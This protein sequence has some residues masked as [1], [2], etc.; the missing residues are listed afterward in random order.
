MAIYRAPYLSS[1][2]RHLSLSPPSAETFS[3]RAPTLSVA[4]SRSSRHA[5]PPR[6]SPLCAA[7]SLGSA[8]SSSTPAA[9][10][11]A[12]KS[13]GAPSSPSTRSSPSRFDLRRGPAAPPVIAKLH[14][15]L[16]WIRSCE[17]KPVRHLSS[18]ED[19]RKVVAF[20]DQNLAALRSS[21]PVISFA[22][23]RRI[24]VGKNRRHLLY[25]PVP[26]ICVIVPWFAGN[27]SHAVHR[28]VTL[29]PSRRFSPLLGSR[30]I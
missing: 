28:R 3:P 1:F 14:R 16:C 10:Y 13:T 15:H 30:V 25:L 20:V 4:G 22:V 5:L 8:K 29:K 26:S 11:F 19:R 27:R 18:T 24:S 21:S 7:T 6:S 17:E 23:R 9:G 2:G 12:P